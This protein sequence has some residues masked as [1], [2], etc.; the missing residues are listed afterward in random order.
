M[1]MNYFKLLTLP[2]SPLW[3]HHS[4]QTPLDVLYRNSV[5]MPLS[6]PVSYIPHL[7]YIFTDDHNQSTNTRQVSKRSHNTS[8]RHWQAQHWLSRR[9]QFNKSW[10]P[11]D[12]YF[13]AEAHGYQETVF[14]LFFQYCYLRVEI[15]YRAIPFVRLALIVK[16]SY[17]RSEKQSS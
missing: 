15:F 12:R 8:W 11:L 17:F 1:Q 3:I 14:I 16:H 4:C 2:I 9:F 13:T 5:Q 6:S 7:V 10:R